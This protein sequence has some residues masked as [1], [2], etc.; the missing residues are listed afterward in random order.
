MPV[1]Q[2]FG[3]GAVR[4]LKY[5]GEEAASEI[6]QLIEAVIA[7]EDELEKWEAL[8]NRALDLEGGVTRNSHPNAIDLV[9]DVFNLFLAKFPL[10][11]AYWKKYANWEFSIGGPETADEIYERGVAA[12]P[13]S[14]DLWENYCDFK[15]MTCHDNNTIREIFER[16]ASFVGLDFFSSSFWDK[17]IEFE[18]RVQ[19]PGKVTQLLKRASQ[20]PTYHFEKY[21][22]KFYPLIV[23][24]EPYENLV[25]EA[26]LDGITTKVKVQ[27]PG[28]NPES[29]EFDREIRKEIYNWYCPGREERSHYIRVLYEFELA[30]KRHYFTTAELDHEELEGWRKYLDHHEKSETEQNVMNLYER[31]LVPCALHEEFWGRYARWLASRN[32][33]EDA[34][35]VYMKAGCIFIPISR[36][37]IRLTW[38]RFEEKLG[39][40]HVAR[41]IHVSILEQLPGHVETITSL[42]GLA[43]RHEGNHAAIQVLDE[44]IEIEKNRL[45]EKMAQEG[46]LEADDFEA[47]GHLVAEQARIL[48]KCEGDVS[49][50]RQIF[51]SKQDQFLASETFWAK[52]LDFEASQPF[53]KGQDT[54]AYVKAVYD[55]IVGN[56]HLNKEAKE[57]LS[58]A[59]MDFILDRGDKD[60]TEEWMKI[61]REVHGYVSKDTES[62]SSK[63]AQNAAGNARKNR[64]A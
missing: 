6:Q 20:L 56:G 64:T 46:K 25:D 35:I 58:K 47:C 11:Y 12:I 52:Y 34:R 21:F 16:A 19:E 45:A 24:S 51:E 23:G 49:A 53:V 61:H 17:Y 29:I 41:D 60:A 33:E 13:K 1:D 2:F 26:T 31:C 43:R 62:P 42:A 4:Q 55:K 63:D 8:L 9:R 14:A 30:I 39:R 18:E 38:A 50:A 40:I 59:Y 5:V 28:L 7:N 44:Y 3:R 54:H 15:I 36:P 22:Q 27:N 57:H 32:R 10:L 48:W 37:E